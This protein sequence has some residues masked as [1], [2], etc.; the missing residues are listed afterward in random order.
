MD[1]ANYLFRAYFA[2]PRL[3]TSKGQPTGGLYGFTQMM[4]KLIR[5]E[6]PDYIAI[7]LDT[8]EP[9]F[10]DKIYEEYK[11]TRPEPPNDMVAQF[12]Y[13]HPIIEALGLPYVEKPGF[14]ADDIIGT[15]A[16]RFA[17][18]ELEVVIVSGD[19]DLMQLVGPGVSML[20]EMKGIRFGQKEVRERFGVSPDRVVEVLGLAGDPSDNVP[21]VPGVGL[22][23][24]SKLIAKYGSIEAVVAN[25]KGLGTAMAEKILKHS[26]DAKFARQLVTIDTSVSLKQGLKDLEPGELKLKEA[27]E[28]FKE[29]EFSRLLDELTPRTT[30]SYQK[31]QLITEE[32]DLTKL[33]NLLKNKD[34]LSFDLET[35]SLY[36]VR[37]NIVG[38]AIAWSPGEA[39]YV[40]VGHRSKS[41]KKEGE[42]FEVEKKPPKQIS[43]QRVFEL[44]G[45]LLAD[46]RIRKVGQNLGYDLT[47]LKRQ[48]ITIAG[49]QF[50]TMLA[51]YLLDPAGDHG[52][53]ALARTHLDHKTIRYEDVVGKGKDK[54]EFAEV[55]LEAA[56]DYACEDADVALR[57]ERIFSPRLEEEGVGDL[58]RRI[59]MP[60]VEVLVDMQLAGVKVDAQRLSA[61]GQD[62]QQ[63]LEE[64]EGRIHSL[65]GEPFNIN[66]PRQLGEVLFTKLGFKG[67]KRTKTGYSTSQS[68]LEELAL[69]HEL[70]Q[71]VLDYRS[72]AKLKSTNVDALIS[73]INP[74]TGRVHTSFNQAATA[75]GRL[76]SSD[77]N[78]Q[79]I[80]VRS[81]EGRK[82]REAFICENGC[83]LV[84]ADYSQIEL[85]LLAHMSGDGALLDAFG[86]GHDVHAITASGIF[87][88]PA[89]RISDVQRSVG[90][91]VNFATIY[92]QTAYGLSRQLRIEV[93]EAAAYIESYFEKYPQVASYRRQVIERAREE[94][95]VRTLFGRRRRLPDLASGNLQAAQFAERAAFNTVLQGTAADIIKRAMIEIHSSLSEIS[96]RSRMILQVHDELLFEVPQSDLDRVVSLV[97]E[98]MER[99]ADLAVPLVA[100][101]GS[102]SNWAQAHP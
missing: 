80:P 48:G 28:L 44:L 36:P 41:A 69:E 79:N 51:S 45:P 63:R 76:S 31:Y 84:S 83:V 32:K 26:G 52:L 82:I 64:L 73:L 23:T 46:E 101:V 81:E 86:R 12:P 9:T 65:V 29:L 22:K 102:G 89:D 97:K 38:L 1:G 35:T 8:A 55:A 62:F 30:I 85:R 90:K 77:P 21:G 2:L 53:D 14:E 24:A 34:T 56:R 50:D 99:A 39:A 100:E 66:S 78:L 58:F 75:T 61:L 88:V 37:A 15:L 59:E 98:R 94:G 25:A 17:S 68:V 67:G 6:K 95:E 3:S 92:G 43:P 4:L 20:D 33:A 10:R 72:L 74:E 19:K 7:C 11:A 18:D 70:P 57:L 49:T 47:I 5:E 87:G 93:E 71:L 91:T 42:L 27:R 96:P 13:V 60:L 16:R 54:L 40:P